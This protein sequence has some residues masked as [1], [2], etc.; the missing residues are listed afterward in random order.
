LTGS[1]KHRR[2]APRYKWKSTSSHL[3]SRSTSHCNDRRSSRSS[4][5]LIGSKKHR[6][7]APRYNWK[8]TWVPALVLQWPLSVLA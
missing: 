1:K 3:L 2:K 6:R 8:S 7:K 5:I 4:P